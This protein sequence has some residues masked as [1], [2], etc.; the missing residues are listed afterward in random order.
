M[1]CGRVKMII[2]LHEILVTTSFMLLVCVWLVSVFMYICIRIISGHLSV[3]PS[4][5]LYLTF[6][7]SVILPMYLTI[8]L[9]LSSFFRSIAVSTSNLGLPCP[10]L[11][12]YLPT[13]LSTQLSIYLSVIIPTFLFIYSPV[14]NYLMTTWHLPNQ[15]LPNYPPTFLSV[16]RRTWEHLDTSLTSPFLPV[17]QTPENTWTPP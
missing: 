17:Y 9:Y 1:A 12:F 16:Y 2:P 5:Y 3:N 15:S 8:C 11:Q 6:Y 13:F 4:I 10:S 14:Y 7:L